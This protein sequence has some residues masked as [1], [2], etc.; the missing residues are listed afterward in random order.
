M[1]KG[2]QIGARADA[3][4]DDPI[5]ML[6]D[7]HR[8]IESFLNILCVVV[9]RANGRTLTGEETAAI[10]A[11]LNYFRAGGERHN[12]DEEQSLFQR[13]R[14]ADAAAQLDE[15]G[16]LE[17]DHRE[18]GEMHHRADELYSAWIFEGT[19]TPEQHRELAT[20]TSNLK[21]IYEHH[22]ELEET[23]VFPRA[24]RMLEP[25]AIAA[26]GQEFRARRA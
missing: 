22:I 6:K 16:G 21:Q 8:R 9:D 2:I 25:D 5:G 11:A 23:V 13:M 4:F 18:A 26:M 1:H 7:C 19:L 17:H 20:A 12:A 10:Q 24:A 15:I 3:G 14:A